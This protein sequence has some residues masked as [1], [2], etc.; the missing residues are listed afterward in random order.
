LTEDLRRLRDTE[1]C[2]IIV[3]HEM[4]L[5]RNACD[6]AIGM[7]YGRIV[8]DGLLD[9]VVESKDLQRAYLGR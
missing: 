2:V 4:D 5:V 9:E 3:E 1:I 8:A 6:R 7:G